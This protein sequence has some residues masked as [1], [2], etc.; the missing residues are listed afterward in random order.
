MCAAGFQGRRLA[1]A[2]HQG[3][4]GVPGSKLDRADA[5]RGRLRVIRAAA[6]T[7]TGFYVIEQ[8]VSI[9]GDS[10]TSNDTAEAFVIVNDSIN[11]RDYT[12][13]NGSSYIA[14]GSGFNGNKGVLG[15]VYHIYQSSQ[16]TSGTFYLESPVVGDS[17]SLS[18]FSMTSGLPDSASVQ[19]SVAYEM[20][21]K[22]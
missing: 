3:L 17:V 5:M 9:P 7:D 8:I 13:I 4:L 6:P 15:Q 10:F 2:S 12:A 19:S 1:G 11:A 14:G 16:V 20:R 18:L 22:Q 21:T